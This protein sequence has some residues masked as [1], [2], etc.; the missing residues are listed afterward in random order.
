M[1]KIKT[2]NVEISATDKEIRQKKKMPHT[3]VLLFGLVI[4][5]CLLTYVV[6]AGN[7][8]RVENTELQQ[9]V[10]VAGSFQE[11][12]A[13]HVSPLLIFS[14]FFQAICD[15]KTATLMFFIMIIGGV[16]EI[17]LYTNCMT[18]LCERLLTRFKGKELWAIPFFVCCF[19]VF[20]FTMGLTTA[21]IIFVPLGIAAAQ[22]LGL[23]K[24]SGLAMIALGTNAGFT[25]G[26]FNPFTVG[27]AQTIAEI[28]LYSDTW[29][30]WL[31]LLV[32][33]FVT[34]VYIMKYAAKVRRN[35]GKYEFPSESKECAFENQIH[36]NMSFIEK[37][38]IAEFFITFVILSLGIALSSWKMPEIVVMFMVMGITIGISAGFGPSK[39]CDIFTD[40]CRKMM[41]GVFVIGI[42]AT[43]RLVLF[44]GNILDTI[45][46]SLINLVYFLPQPIQLLGM[47]FFTALINFLITSGSAKAALIMPIL[48][49]MADVLGL[50]RASSVYAF[51]LGDGVTNLASPISTTLNGVMAVAEI[52][53]DEWI[54]FYIP[55]VG[56]YTLVGAGL[57][58]LAA[59]I[60]Y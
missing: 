38:V 27:V 14:K 1:A 50:S 34:S 45:T 51:H 3:F 53:Y 4:I 42:A 36:T 31:T 43:I 44:E 56:I 25:A 28:P 52:T 2:K 10:V 15:S 60:G 17:V 59:T 55:L 47:F 26:V 35:S 39:I 18:K 48:T 20:G 37:L 12:E 58:F 46:N 40:G 19:S 30:R 9:T 5:A 57:T 32:L 21:S 49:P 13:N 6:P 11:I 8:E 23:D 29:I 33:N 54:K 16:F 22:T 24:M 41:K 7:F